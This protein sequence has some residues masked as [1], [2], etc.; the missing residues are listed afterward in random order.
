MSSLEDHQIDCSQLY[1]PEH[2]RA[3][4]ESKQEDPGLASRLSAL[5]CEHT[6]LVATENKYVFQVEPSAECELCPRKQSLLVVKHDGT[7]WDC[8]SKK[9]PQKIG[10]VWTEELKFRNSDGSFSPAPIGKQSEFVGQVDSSTQRNM[11]TGVDV[12]DH[13]HETTRIHPISKMLVDHPKAKC[14]AI[15]AGMSLGKTCAIGVYLQEY[16]LELFGSRPKR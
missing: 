1:F 5:V 8:W 2:S 16:L 10:V 3:E 12:R 7:V 14:I 15:R 6:T 4:E 9:K 11:W 13:G